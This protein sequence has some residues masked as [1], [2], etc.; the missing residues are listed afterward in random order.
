MKRIFV[1]AAL[2]L[3]SACAGT[4]DLGKGKTGQSFAVRGASYDAIWNASLEAVREQTG[5]QKLEVEKNLTV[6]KADKAAGIITASTGMS[7]LSWGEVVGVYITPAADAPV[8]TIEVESRSKMQT[9]VFANNWEE[10]IIADIK[11][12]LGVQ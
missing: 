4:Q 12:K 3:V 7:L 9:N 1:F 8:H 11:R 2:M 6:Q 10:E 5:D